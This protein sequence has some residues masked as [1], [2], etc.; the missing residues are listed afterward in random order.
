L[1]VSYSS[2]FSTYDRN[3][4]F[5]TDA[6]VVDDSVSFFR[7]GANAS[8]EDN[9]VED[10]TVRLDNEWHLSNSHDLKIGLGLSSFNSHYFATMNDTMR[11]VSRE[12]EAMQGF[13]Y[14]QDLWKISP[15]VEL[16]AG[17]RGVYYDKTSSTYL[18][19]RASLIYSLS[20]KI[21]LKGAWGHYHQF[22]NRIANENILEGSRDFWVLA[23]EELKPDFAEHF[24]LGASYENSDY[25]FDVEG[26]YKDLDNMVEYTRRVTRRIMRTDVARGFFQGTG[27]SRG[28][29]FLAQ[30]KR[31]KLTG[32]IGYTL[33]KVEYDFP[34]LNNGNPFP[35]SHDRT[36]EL[37][38][39][40][41]YS[42]GNWDLSATWVYATGKAYTAPESQ[43][44]I[45]LLDGSQ[46]SYIH[47]SDKNAYRLPGY[48]RLDFSISR[49]FET[50]T[51][52]F[53][54]GFSIFN[55][56][57]NKNIWY[58]KYDLDT[59]PV[60]VTDVTM[61]GITPTVYFQI[62]SR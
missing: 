28:L 51:A 2:Y 42:I 3:Q 53:A 5:T 43:Y 36:H 14:L 35:A 16:T 12:T 19:P 56:Y 32:W 30:K 18:E 44:Y 34:E 20:E 31:G 49:K 8:E 6:A 15:S 58:R 39:V 41:R 9:E 60:A 61:L 47:V 48:H 4:S 57:N 11:L 25:L 13:L 54:L 62:Y 55:L 59:V 38:V 23:D 26:Y 1:L 40:S 33:G 21:T 52:E 46:R 50:D 29:E 22:V 24:I 10:L 27:F 45:E 17:V 37:N 7:A